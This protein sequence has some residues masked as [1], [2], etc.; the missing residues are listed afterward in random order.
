MWINIYMF[1]S[2]AALIISAAPSLSFH[3]KAPDTPGDR[4]V[5]SAS[6]LCFLITPMILPYNHSFAKQRPLVKLFDKRLR[7]ALII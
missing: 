2:A 4:P 7:Y 3:T 5:S 1:F 6:P